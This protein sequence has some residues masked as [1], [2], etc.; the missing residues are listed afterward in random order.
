MRRSFGLVLLLAGL[1]FATGSCLVTDKNDVSL[2]DCDGELLH[3]QDST[4]LSVVKNNSSWTTQT[5]A[6]A[7]SCT[8]IF[9]VWYRWNSDIDAQ[10]P[11]PPNVSFTFLPAGDSIIPQ[12]F[13][14][15][16]PLAGADESDK[17]W[18]LV[19]YAP[20]PTSGSGNTTVFRI[21]ARLDPNAT[22]GVF[23]YTDILYRHSPN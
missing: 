8:T 13:S 17:G 21:F 19:S 15:R 16:P 11:Y 5:P 14:G 12:K 20:S 10:S 7:G 1:A 2:D 4:L 22:E 18:W 3:A 9:H 23:V 6:A